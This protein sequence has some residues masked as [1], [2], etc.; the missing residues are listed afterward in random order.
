[1][2]RLALT[3]GPTQTPR[4]IAAKAQRRLTEIVG[5]S[6]VAALPEKLVGMY[7]RLRF[8]NGRL[9]KVESDAIEQ[10]LSQIEMAVQRAR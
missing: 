3:R 8:G 7:Y 10:A 2:A 4:E 5:N 6:E 9:D 1:L